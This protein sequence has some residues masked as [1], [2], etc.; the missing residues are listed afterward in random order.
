M[1]Q[2]PSFHAVA[3]AVALA[4]TAVAGAAGWLLHRPGASPPVVPVGTVVPAAASEVTGTLVRGPISFYMDKCV[5]C[6]GDYG[7][8][9]GETFYDGGYD[10]EMMKAKVKLMCE[11]QAQHPLSGRSLEVQAAYQLSLAR[12]GVFVGWTAQD[13][14]RWSGEVTPG[15][16][17]ELSW[18]GGSVNAT[19]AGHAWTADLGA[20]AGAPAVTVA[21][22]LGQHRAQFEA[23]R[24]AYASAP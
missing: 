1:S 22:R 3:A 18:P 8:N 9:Y 6:H 20:A 16:E 17:V 12:R 21:A 11:D 19:V 4:V 15:A 5:A 14:T 24:A 7:A 2:Q 10:L 23:P 13:G